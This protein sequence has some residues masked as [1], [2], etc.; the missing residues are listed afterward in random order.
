MQTFSFNKRDFRI[1]GAMQ[2]EGWG[3]DFSQAGGN[4]VPMQMV[5][6]IGL[7][8]TRQRFHRCGRC[9]RP[10]RCGGIVA[11]QHALQVRQTFGAEKRH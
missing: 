9:R 6:K 11:R 5:G 1:R 4:R 8:D 10:G 3:P 7:Q 2:D